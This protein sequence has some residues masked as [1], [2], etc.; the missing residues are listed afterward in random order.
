MTKQDVAAFVGE[1]LTKHGITDPGKRW[2]LQ[3]PLTDLAWGEIVALGKEWRES[4]ARI[5]T[6]L[7]EAPPEEARHNGTIVMRRLVE[8][9][10]TMLTQTLDQ[11]PFIPSELTDDLIQFIIEKALDRVEGGAE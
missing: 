6:V 7:E 8:A 1:L 5:M 2:V 3:E 9:E 4:V 10:R 11:R